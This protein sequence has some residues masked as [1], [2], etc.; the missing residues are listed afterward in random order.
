MQRENYFVEN[1]QLRAQ[2]DLRGNSAGTQLCVS[3]ACFYLQR[4]IFP[5]ARSVGSL[6]TGQHSRGRKAWNTRVLLSFRAILAHSWF[7]RAGGTSRL[8]S[9]SISTPFARPRSQWRYRSFRSRRLRDCF[10]LFAPDAGMGIFI[11][12]GGFRLFK[13]QLL[14]SRFVQSCFELFIFKT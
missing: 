7:A 12:S 4:V 8:R 9:T 13:K 10:C 2:I 11:C 1:I 14:S 3:S 5:E 6:S